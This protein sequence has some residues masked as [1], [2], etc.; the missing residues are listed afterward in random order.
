MMSAMTAP[1][2]MA[3]PMKTRSVGTSPK[4]THIQNGISGVSSVEI[5]AAWPDGSRREPRK[6]NVR[7][8]AT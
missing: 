6:N 1:I 5:S 4:P 3:P 7:P 8:I 2:T